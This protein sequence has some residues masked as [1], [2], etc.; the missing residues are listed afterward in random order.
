MSFNAI[1]LS[2]TRHNR[3]SL[4]LFA[5]LL[6]LAL[7]TFVLPDSASAATCADA[8][9]N[10]ATTGSRLS[11]DITSSS[12]F[13]DDTDEWDSDVV[14]I[15]HNVAG[16]LVFGAKGEAIEGTLYVWDAIEEEQDLVGSATLAGGSGN[17]YTTPV[18]EGDYC[19]EITNYDSSEGEY[20]LNVNFLD[21]CT[22]GLTPNA[23][24]GE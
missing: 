13:V 1:S 14:K 10:W 11:H 20:V 16:I 9:A 8:F 7:C 22:L 2:E 6:A 5:A 18:D 17:T 4:R 15:R 21:A 19:F 12:T 24:G 3:F 23:C